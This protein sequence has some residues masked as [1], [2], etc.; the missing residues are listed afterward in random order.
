MKNTHQISVDYRM[1]APDDAEVLAKLRTQQLIEEGNAEQTDISKKLK[2]YFSLSLAD[3]SLIC[4][5]GIVDDNIVATGGLCFYSLP[6]TFS[7]PTGRNAYLTNMY[8][9]IG[10]RR[11]GIATVLVSKLIDEAKARHYA[12][13]KLHA[14]EQGRG[15]YEAA[16]FV[17]TSGYMA[18]VL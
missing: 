6:P 5:L 8:T 15:I 18:L 13:I 11:S 16:G 7:N 12:V 3:G 2:D 4:W 9:V 1:A 10:Y 14:S 17:R